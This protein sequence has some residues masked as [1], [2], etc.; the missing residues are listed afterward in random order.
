MPVLTGTSLLGALVGA[1]VAGTAAGRV[2]VD[3]AAGL[4]LAAGR[5]EAEGVAAGWLLCVEEAL[6]VGKAAGGVTL[7]A[8]MVVCALVALGTRVGVGSGLTV[9]AAFAV[10]VTVGVMAGVAAG[11]AT[12]VGLVAFGVIVDAVAVTVTMD[13]LAVSA[14]LRVGKTI[15]ASVS[16]FMSATVGASAA[17]CRTCSHTF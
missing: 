5:A 11:V 3:L 8:G 2:G 1:R 15:F 17:A 13:G 7:V 10:D 4:A 14:A 9:G 6:L 12:G 16:V